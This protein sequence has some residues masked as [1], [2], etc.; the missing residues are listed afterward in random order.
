MLGERPRYHPRLMSPT[1]VRNLAIVLGIAALGVIWRTGFGEA[2]KAISQAISVLFVVAIGY[3]LYRYFTSN[4]LTWYAIPRIRRYVFVACGVGLAVVLLFGFPLL[5][6]HV[7][8]FGVV[9][10]LTALAL[11]MVWIIQESRRL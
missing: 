9:A 1:A 7:G 8:A 5:Q 6:P 11:T 2:G 4:T 10:I 3:A